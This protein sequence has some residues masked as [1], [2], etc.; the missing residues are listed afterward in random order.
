MI[1][2]DKNPI[3]YDRVTGSPITS[4]RIF[5]SPIISD[6]FSDGPWGERYLIVTWFA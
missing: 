6:S 1:E 2:S 4:D 3:T 5:D